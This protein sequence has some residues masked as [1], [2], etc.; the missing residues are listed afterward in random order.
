MCDRGFVASDQCPATG[1]G[2][3]F[4]SGRLPRREGFPRVRDVEGEGARSSDRKGMGRRDP[5]P[6]RG[7][8]RGPSEPGQRAES[9]R[10]DHHSE[11]GQFCLA[12]IGVCLVNAPSEQ[13][14]CLTG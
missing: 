13:S 14:T 3:V 2:V 11:V 4:R 8:T 7:K 9:N 10:D 5:A 12:W 1:E 6:L